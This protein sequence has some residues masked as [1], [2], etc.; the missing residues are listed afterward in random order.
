MFAQ[1]EGRVLS[2]PA[3]PKLGTSVM[4]SYVPAPSASAAATRVV[5]SEVL[6]CFSATLLVII[7][8]GGNMHLNIFRQVC[9]FCRVLSGS[10][11]HHAYSRVVAWPSPR[12]VGD[13]LMFG[14]AL[15]CREVR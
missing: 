8:V 2:D 9:V 12:S 3:L 15:I 11:Q 4:F 10:R 5:I 14:K 1:T 13:L 6:V 7:I